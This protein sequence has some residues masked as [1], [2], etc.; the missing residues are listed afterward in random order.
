MYIK[1]YESFLFKNIPFLSPNISD[2]GTSNWNPFQPHERSLFKV[3]L[4][5]KLRR[6]YFFN[7]FK[8][9]LNFKVFD[10]FFMHINHILNKKKK[11]P[12]F[13]CSWK[14]SINTCITLKSAHVSQGYKP[15]SLL[16][17]NLCGDL[18]LKENTL[19][20]VGALIRLQRFH[21]FD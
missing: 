4:S 18:L 11:S 6:W 7:F 14:K 15:R 13:D 19:N 17:T 10:E 16:I 5:K 9:L 2:W 8:I 3:H 21:L 20:T 1:S 12:S